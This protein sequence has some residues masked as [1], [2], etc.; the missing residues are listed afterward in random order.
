MLAACAGAFVRS[1][2]AIKNPLPVP[3]VAKRS[4]AAGQPASLKISTICLAR[5]NESV[6]LAV[7][8]MSTAPEGAPRR[9]STS[10]FC[11]AGEIVR[12]FKLSL[13]CKRACSAIAVF[14]CCL[15]IPALASATSFSRVFELSTNRTIS[16]SLA[17][18]M[19]R[20]AGPA[21][22][23]RI[24]STATPIATKRAAIFCPLSIQESS[25]GSST[26]YPY[27]D[28]GVAGLVV[29]WLVHRRKKAHHMR[30]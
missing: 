15:L 22:N 14:S 4:V 17:W 26:D 28:L 20:R 25:V 16:A 7:H 1:W 2:T 23:P 18:S 11:C 29:I 30:K 13:N 3:P 8:Q 9:A 27:R 12:S 5:P 21:I 10:I 6:S 19:R 24:N